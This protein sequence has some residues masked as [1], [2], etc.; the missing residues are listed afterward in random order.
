MRAVI[1][2]VSTENGAPDFIVEIGSH[3]KDNNLSSTALIM[4]QKSNST[5]TLPATAGTRISPGDEQTVLASPASNDD[6]LSL[7]AIDAYSVTERP[8][9]P[10]NESP[11]DTEASSAWE[12]F[13]NGTADTPPDFRRFASCLATHTRFV[14]TMKGVAKNGLL[15]ETLRF[16]KQYYANPRT[17][18]V[19]GLRTVEGM[20]NAALEFLRNASTIIAEEDEKKHIR[21][22]KVAQANNRAHR[23]QS[24]LNDHEKVRLM[25]IIADPRYREQMDWVFQKTA[26][27][28][29]LDSQ[30]PTFENVVGPLFRNKHLELHL[31]GNVAADEWSVA[32]ID[33][34]INIDFDRHPQ[35]LKRTFSAMRSK[36]TRIDDRYHASGQGNGD[37]WNYCKIDGDHRRD[38][39]MLVIKLFSNDGNAVFNVMTRAV[40]DAF[41]GDSVTNAVP[42]M[43]TP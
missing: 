12:A 2:D 24:N 27:R 22:M 40:D 38:P 8:A 23:N 14:R 28:S 13:V 4:A 1:V 32:N 21:A 41:L 30:K 18:K 20:R 29:V 33:P 31:P 39:V 11:L 15:Y 19:S 16:I 17:F 10:S 42:S 26:P 7:S 35:Q 36:F 25:C 37:F 34:H 3:R 9:P 5:R 6:T 43:T